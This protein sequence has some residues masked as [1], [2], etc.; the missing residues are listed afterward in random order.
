MGRKRVIA[1]PQKV[2][3]NLNRED[4]EAMK[5]FYPSATAA[6]A[7]RALVHQHVTQLRAK[8]SASKETLVPAIDLD[9]DG[10]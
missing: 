3:L 7:I 1:D 2:T 8:I 4:Y 9:L 6:V 5:A 10:V